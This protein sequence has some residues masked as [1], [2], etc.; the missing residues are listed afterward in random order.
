MM[1][2]PL[3]ALISM[4]AFK[5]RLSN[6]EAC[7]VVSAALKKK[8]IKCQPLPVGDGGAGSLWTVHAALGGEIVSASSTDPLGRKIEAQCLVLPNA[9]HPTS[10]YLESSEVCGYSLVKE[11]ERDAMRASSLGLGELIKFGLEKWGQSLEKIYVGLGDSAISDMGMGMLCGLGVTFQDEG[12][13]PLWGNA[14]SLRSIRSFSLPKNPVLNKVKFIVLCD[15]LNPLCGPKG[16]ARTFGPQKGASPGQVSQIEQGMENFAALIQ[17]T[18]GRNLR[19]EPMTGSAGGLAAAFLGFFNT[20]L[21]HGARFLMDWIHFDRILADH[22]FLIVGEG[23]TDGQTL[24]GKAPAECLE[25]AQRQGKKV[26]LISG[27]LGEGH[28]SL[29]K[30]SSV[31]GLFACGENPTA[32]DALYERVLEVFSD[33]ELVESLG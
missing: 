1:K 24:S 3:S 29:L 22:A 23:K 14:A 7:D 25:R 9:K 21:V 30:K 10:L 32:K 17:K 4:S 2:A 6:R 27:V 12:G 8:K 18:T 13:R 5:G 19:S 33:E 28:E 26:V 31:A 20:E 11:S 16:S 15:V